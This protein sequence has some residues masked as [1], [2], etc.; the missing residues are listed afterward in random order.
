MTL[1]GI[2]TESGGISTDCDLL[3][4][5]LSA[6]TVSATPFQLTI[7]DKLS[8]NVKPD[9]INGRTAYK[10][11]EA[12]ALRVNRI[13]LAEHDLSAITYREAKRAIYKWLQK[14]NQFYGPLTPFGQAVQRDIDL[15]TKYTLSLESWYQFCDRRVI[16]TV[17]LGKF[18]QLLGIIP[19]EQSLSLS[20]VTK[21]LGIEVDES[22]VH[23]AEYDVLLGVRYLEKLEQIRG[24]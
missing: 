4:I 21:Y 7:V 9:P 16:D 3:T 5:N 19:Q 24:R 2:D 6:V 12:E 1:L 20:K 8:L 15:I 13:N 17:S 18:A 22:L 14:V 10:N 11:I 23:T